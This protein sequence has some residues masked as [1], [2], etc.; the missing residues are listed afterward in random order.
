[1][2]LFKPFDGSK[3]VF[4]DVDAG[5]VLPGI[6]VSGSVNGNFHSIGSNNTAIYSYNETLVLQVNDRKW[7]LP[8]IEVRYFHKIRDKTTVF[9]IIEDDN[10][11]TI[12]YDSW[13]S[14]IP[15]FNPI[16]PEMDED[17]DFYGYLFAVWKDISL[18][19]VLI[20]RWK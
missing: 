17:E 5:E 4:F 7:N 9:E 19:E 14:T 2:I 15:G 12:E 20:E 11:T 8:S 1:M 3:K 6:D 16:E 18:Q 13:W 10:C